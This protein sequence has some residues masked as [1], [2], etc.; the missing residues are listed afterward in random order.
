MNI[1][2]CEQEEEYTS[3]CELPF[4]P[5]MQNVTFHLITLSFAAVVSVAFVACKCV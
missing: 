2:D 1:A 4:S 5:N 3:I